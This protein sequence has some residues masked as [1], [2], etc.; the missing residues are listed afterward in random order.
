MKDQNE[1]VLNAQK[2]LTK[3]GVVAFAFG[4]SKPNQTILPNR[5]IRMIA[6]CRARHENAPIFTQ[7][8]V[9]ICDYPVEYTEEEPGSPPP[10]LRIARGA[11]R[12]AKSRG[13]TELWIV[14]AKPHLWR[15]ERDLREAVK[16]CRAQIKVHVAPETAKYGDE[17]WFCPDSTQRRTSSCTEWNKR[18]KI[19]RLMPFFIYRLVAG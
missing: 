11:V 7:L 6:L 3:A 15:A 17:Q 16:E 18:E 12:W 10:T 4:T 5:R 9:P 2:E 19:L 14:A 8:D 13:I 1:T